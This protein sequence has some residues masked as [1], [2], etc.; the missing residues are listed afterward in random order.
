MKLWL[1][2]QAFLKAWQHPDKAR[3]FLEENK[4][5]LEEPD[6]S[7]LRFLTLMQQSGRLVDFLKEDIQSFNDAEIGAAVR[8]IHQDCSAVLEEY[9]TVR[10]VMDENEGSTVKI[11]Q[12]YDP[13]M[14]K[15]V[16]QVKKPP[17]TG[18]LVHKGWKAHKRSLPKKMGDHRH[19]VI[20]PA[21]VEVR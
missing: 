20:C 19:D 8:E 16:G 18:V 15:I 6:W 5:E 7:H 3:T 9:V 1:A 12:G 2:L 10:P 11:S 17:F 13:S 14:I 21:E 4:E